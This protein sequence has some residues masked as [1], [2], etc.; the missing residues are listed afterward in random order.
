MSENKTNFEDLQS[1]TL[2]YIRFPISIGVVF[3]HNSFGGPYVDFQAIDYAN[4][5]GHDVYDIFRLLTKTLATI[6]TPYF[7]LISGYFYFKK[8]D[9]LDKETYWSKTKNRVL[10][11]LVPYFVWNL[12]AFL[13]PLLTAVVKGTLPEYLALFSDKN[14]LSIFWNYK[15]WSASNNV[16]LLGQHLYEAAPLNV[17]LWFLRDLFIMSVLSPLF[18]WFVKKTK[19]YGVLFLGLC[20]LTRTWTSIPGFS[21]IAVFFFSLGAYL[22]LNK[23]NLVLVARKYKYIILAACLAAIVLDTY[24]LGQPVQFLFIRQV[25]RFTGLFSAI[26]IGSYLLERGWA[27]LNNRKLAKSSFFIYIAHAVSVLGILI[28]GFTYI[29]SSVTSPLLLAILYSAVS[30]STVAACYLGYLLMKRYT[31]KFLNII[32]GNR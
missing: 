8:I 24:F 21:I 20:F 28:N 2:D 25:Y 5:S 15:V 26:I 7:F 3:I 19:I 29:F 6:A 18:Y 23:L 9:V 14:I 11:L 1:K 30:I 17:P 13:V 4:L 16:N 27:K 32:T 22:G 12:L 31:P 10:T